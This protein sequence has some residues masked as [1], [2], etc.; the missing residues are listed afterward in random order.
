LDLF[1]TTA[2]RY[3]CRPI[4]TLIYPASEPTSLCSFTLM[5]CA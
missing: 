2:R 1:E 4:R 5:S 3:T